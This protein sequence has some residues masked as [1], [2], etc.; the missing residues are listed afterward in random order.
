M[1]TRLFTSALCLIGLMSGPLIAAEPVQPQ[2]PYDHRYC[3]TCHGVDGRGNIGVRAPR[4][5]G[6]EPWY[7]KRQLEMFRAGVRGK[8]PKD[9][10]GLA[11]QPM[12]AKL[13]DEHIA[14]IVTWAGGW[15]VQSAQGTLQGDVAAGEKLYRT[16]AVCHGA[17]AGGNEALGA[18]ALVGQS[19]WYLLTQLRN[20]KNAYRGGH[21]KDTY[22]AQMRAAVQALPDDKAMVD[23]ISY[24]NQLEPVIKPSEKV[25]M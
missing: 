14:D 23:V 4:L 11:M 15:S 3:T 20:F 8:H 12:A 5:A 22:G 16:C 18:P 1:T 7:L 9:T 17:G 13:S 10:E 6:M 2:A 24:I 19:D 21:P 25:G